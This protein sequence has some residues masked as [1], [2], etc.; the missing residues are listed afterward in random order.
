MIS[1]E[2]NQCFGKDATFLEVSRIFAEFD[3]F[4]KWFW[5]QLFISIWQPCTC[6]RVSVPVS[7]FS[8]LVL[9][10]KATGLETLNIARNWF[11][12]IFITK[13]FF[14]CCIFR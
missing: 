5:R 2:K 3:H 12:K 1:S 10:S 8:V 6:I 7:K 9:V 4:L 13:R 11:S 14:L